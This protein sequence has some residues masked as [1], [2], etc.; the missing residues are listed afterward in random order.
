MAAFQIS[1]RV[2]FAL[3]DSGI[4]EPQDLIGRRAAVK[5]EGWR[6]TIHETLTN[7][8]VDPA[9]IIE[10]DVEYDAMEMLYSGEVDVWTGYV[11][12]EPIE[13]RLA[14]YDVNLIFPAEYGVGAYEGLLVIRQDTLDQNP[15]L[16]ARFVRAS[17]RG[18][19]YTVEHPDEAAEV[20]A[21]WQPGESLEFHQMAMRALVPLIDMGQ[22]PIGWIDAERWRIAMGTAYD[23]ERPGYT[24]QFVQAVEQ[25]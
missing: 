22:V 13:A 10:V 18:W 5:S 9:E 19:Q 1:P 23:P 24:M 3:S 4:Q 25:K 8:G 7:A 11:H 21:Q 16:V 12:D 17:L 2:L 15:N 20:I 14:G 6:R